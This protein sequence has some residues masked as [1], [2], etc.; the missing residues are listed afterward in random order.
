[1][2]LIINADDFGLTKS[3]NQAIVKAHT[4]GVLTSTTIMANMPYADEAINLQKI[5]PNLG[6]GVHLVLTTGKP[7]L[8]NNKTLVDDQ[9]FFK[10]QNFFFN[11]FQYD[12]NEIYD[13]FKA[14]ID[15][16]IHMEIHLSHIDS[17]HHVHGCSM[18][19][20]IM[21]QIQVDYQL[22]MRNLS[23][24]DNPSFWTVANFSDAFYGEQVSEELLLTIIKQCNS[25]ALEIMSHPSYCDEDLQKCSSY[26]SLREKELNILL[27]TKLKKTLQEYGIQFVNYR[28]LY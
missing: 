7:I 23:D 10:K 12:L 20:D 4:E 11:H 14:Q 2:K 13:E 17:H 5:Y 28:N 24:E 3:V 18:I 22:P 15:R 25:S 8:S 26:C 6:F 1:M 21:K 19:K 27:S 16:L 9:G